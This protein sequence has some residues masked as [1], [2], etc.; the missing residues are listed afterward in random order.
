MPKQLRL[1]IWA[2]RISSV[3]YFLMGVVTAVIG[4]LFF[5][6]LTSQRMGI[7][8]MAILIFMA[9]I[10]WGM[11]VFIECVIRGLKQSRYWAWIAGIIVAGIYTPSL[12]LPL[13]ILG[14]VGLLDRETR[15]HFSAG[16]LKKTALP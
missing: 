16:P 7:Y 12:F 6:P 1:A 4:L 15:E 11:G 9:I 8:E 13:G 14:L 5:L 10:S 2:L 3:L